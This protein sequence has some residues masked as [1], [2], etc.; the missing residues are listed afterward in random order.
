MLFETLL[1]YATAMLTAQIWQYKKAAFRLIP[2]QQEALPAFW[3][4]NRLLQPPRDYAL[5][6]GRLIDWA[7]VLQF[8]LQ[9]W[10]NKKGEMIWR[11]R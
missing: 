11:V 6:M 7:T 8:G 1:H 10:I 5:Q 2:S 9:F 4:Q 3:R